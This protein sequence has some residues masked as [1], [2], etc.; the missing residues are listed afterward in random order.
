MAACVVLVDGEHYPPVVMAALA[1]LR[2]GGHEVRAAIFLGGAEKTATVPDLGVPVVTGDP[3][4]QIGRMVAEHAAAVVV[5]LSDEPVVGH[6]RRFELAGAA[7]AAGAVYEGG[8]FRFEPPPRPRLTELPTLAVSG[9]G[10]RTGKTAV[11]IELT[12]HLRD[13][14]ARPC[15]VTMG[16][17]GPPEPVV[18]R[19]GTFPGGP[20]GLA[21]LAARGLH[22]A[23]DYV[24]DAVFAGVDTVGTFRCGAGFFGQT[25][26]DNFA[27]GVAAASALEPGMLVFEGSGTAVPPAAADRSVLVTSADLDPEFLA[28]YAG[29]YR[30]A[31]A[32]AVVTIG[33]DGALARPASARPGLPVF[34]GRYRAEP[35]IAVDGATV[36][37]VTTAPVAA[38][39]HIAAQLGAQGASEVQFVHSLADRRRLEADLGAAPGC[40]VVLVEV[41]AAAADVVIPWAARQ[42][43]ALGLLHNAVD[44]E[45]GVA[46]LA[47]ALG[48]AT[49]S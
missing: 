48:Y 38:A 37:V 21:E 16:R 15:I 1:E 9:T 27:A 47:A 32:D 24:E 25:V 17:G 14:G 49:T 39:P 13:Q 10:K 19:A 41:K 35:S 42:G 20:E 4:S 11:A 3:V 7:L 44:F 31:L 45:G 34:R 33:G 22:A 36:A 40:D 26:R 5:D 46:A 29:P 2:A 28:G 6:R 43:R 12:R 18:L 8:G 23:S 30:L